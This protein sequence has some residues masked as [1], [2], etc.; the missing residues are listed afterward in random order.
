MVMFNLWWSK[1]KQGFPCGSAGKEPTCNA[2]DLDSIPGLGRSPGE[3]K[4]YPLQHSGLENS[5]DCTVL[6]MVLQRVRHDWANFTS[7]QRK[8]DSNFEK[9]SVE[10]PKDKIYRAYDSEM[11]V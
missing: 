3:G 6:Q 7:L 10:T 9:F 4:S 1:G 8:Q 11:Y 5:M 2:E